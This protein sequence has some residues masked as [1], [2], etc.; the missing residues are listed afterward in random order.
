MRVFTILFLLIL[1]MQQ[2]EEVATT[3][4]ETRRKHF[5]QIEKSLV[6][7]GFAHRSYSGPFLESPENFS[8]DRKSVV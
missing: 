7:S 1:F 5:Y 3:D 6:V 8:G 4:P 2:E